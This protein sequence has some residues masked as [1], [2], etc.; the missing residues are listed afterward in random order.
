MHKFKS[1]LAPQMEQL[2]AYKAAMNM[3]IKK[4]E[5]VLQSID[6]YYVDHQITEPTVT[7]EIIFDWLESTTLNNK[8]ITKSLKMG[9]VRSLC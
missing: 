4:Y 3:T 9:V 5:T 2:I 1:V 7:K 6:R 8:P